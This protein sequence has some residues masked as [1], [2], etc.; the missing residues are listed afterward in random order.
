LKS[1]YGRR[2]VKV[3]TVTGRKTREFDSNGPTLEEVQQQEL[4]S[5]GRLGAALTKAIARS[6]EF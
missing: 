2:G 4:Y 6:F 3:R 1:L 5:K